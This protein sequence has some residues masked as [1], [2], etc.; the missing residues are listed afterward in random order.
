MQPATPPGRPTGS[1]ALTLAAADLRRPTA[2][3]RTPETYPGEDRRNV[4]R[5]YLRFAG[6][7]VQ[8]ALTILILTLAGI[9]LDGRFETDPLF[10]VVFLLLGFGGATWSLIHQVLGPDK[11]DK[12]P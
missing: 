8:F 4:E 7:G 3:E 9:W 11:G 5:K 10:T 12:K 6:V 2:L 1:D